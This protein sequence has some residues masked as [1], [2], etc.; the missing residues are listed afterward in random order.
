MSKQNL[1]IFNETYTDVAGFKV[2]DTNNSTL[3]YVAES[4]MGTDVW[5]DDNGYLHLSDGEG[6]F[7]DKS[8]FFYDYDGELIYSYSAAEAQL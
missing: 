3:T 6:S 5:V 7:D 1:T 8:V 2:K 4:D